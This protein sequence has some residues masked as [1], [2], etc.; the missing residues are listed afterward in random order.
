MAKKRGKRAKEI[1]D[2]PEDKRFIVSDGSVLK[3]IRELADALDSMTEDIFRAHVNDFKN[4][5]A[6][7]VRD[8]FNEHDLA[9]ALTEAKTRINSQL[10]VLKCV[11]KKN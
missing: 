5:F 4:D 2:A 11:V 1:V 6:N 8:V 9:K 10:A 3:N 7:W